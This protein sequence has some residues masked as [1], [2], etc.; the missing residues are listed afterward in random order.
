MSGHFLFIPKEVGLSLQTALSL[1]DSAQIK[2]LVWSVTQ[3]KAPSGMISDSSLRLSPGRSF[4]GSGEI[5][6]TELAKVA[7]PLHGHAIGF[8]NIQ[9]AKEYLEDAWFAAEWYGK[10]ISLEVKF[11]TGGLE[12]FVLDATTAAKIRYALPAV[13]EIA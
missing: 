7:Q 8:S 3:L 11:V 4:F 12:F 9:V 6:L 2:E 13:R 10:A 1:I 5:L